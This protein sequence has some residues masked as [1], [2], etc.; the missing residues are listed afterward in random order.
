MFPEEKPVPPRRRRPRDPQTP[1]PHPGNTPSSWWPDVREDHEDGPRQKQVGA[2]AFPVET[3]ASA[4]F[5]ETPSLSSALPSSPWASVVELWRPPLR[6]S[7]RERFFH[8]KHP[9]LPPQGAAIFLT[10]NT[11][12]GISYQETF[13]KG[14]LGRESLFPRWKSWQRFNTRHGIRAFHPDLR[15]CVRVRNRPE[16]AKSSP[17]SG[18]LPGPT[19]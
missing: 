16:S 17:K 4:F 3:E 14:K 12:H 8:Q 18:T 11:P 5:K 2:Q 1:P 15:R 10:R 19:V 9:L 13:S 7:P 6:T